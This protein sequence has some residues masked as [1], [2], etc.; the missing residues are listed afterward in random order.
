MTPPLQTVRR[1]ASK[2]WLQFLV[3]GTGLFAFAPRPDEQ[4]IELD[5][6]VLAGLRLDQARRLGLPELPEDQ[7]R[8]VE[9]RAVEDEVLVREARRLGLDKDDAIIRA[10]L[11]QKMLFLAEELDGASLPLTEAQL[12]AFFDEH[13]ADYTVEGSV[14]FVQ[15]FARSE[16]DALSLR[17]PAEAFSARSADPAA[18]PPLGEPLPVSRRDEMS[19]A[20]LERTYGPAFAEAAGAAP[21]GS[22]TGPVRSQ[23]GWHLLRVIERTAAHPAQFREVEGRVRLDALIARREQAVSRFLTGALRRYDVTVD[24]APLAPSEPTR[25]SA[26][27]TQPSQED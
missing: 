20:E 3:L 8:Q 11:V 10:R 25:R 4:H 13:Q 7:A 15:V 26:P 17:A 24:G 16:Q 18:I 23:H 1:L 2:R 19:P 27:R 9:L 12:R 21:V 22:W 6:Q 5:G 14:E